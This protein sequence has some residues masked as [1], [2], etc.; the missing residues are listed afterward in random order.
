MVI[1]KN[2]VRLIMLLIPY[3]LVASWIQINY[4]SATGAVYIAMGLIALIFY[5]LI[6]TLGFK[7]LIDKLFGIDENWPLDTVIGVVTG[8]L[9]I[10]AMEVS[11]VTMGYPSAIYP[12]TALAEKV[13]LFSTFLVIA[14]LAAV[15]EEIIFRGI[16]A[17]FAWH[18]LK[19]Y[20]VAIIL[21]SVAFAAFHYQAYGAYLPAAYVGAFLIGILLSM[22][23]Q[24]TKSLL[25]C[26]I[27]HS[28]INTHLFIQAEQLLVIGV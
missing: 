7:D 23:A 1:H 10:V 27:I 24:Q 26:I 22:I 15:G 19:Y 6:E 11:F 28:I 9:I 17:W 8:L 13:T 12:Q 5:S 18:S 16:F 4:E 3:L 2:Y 14:F 21:S 20:T 25:P